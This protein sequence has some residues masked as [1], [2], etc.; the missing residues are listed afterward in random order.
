MYL[1]LEQVHWKHKTNGQRPS[2]S[3]PQERLYS[4]PLPADGA[5]TR[6]VLKIRRV[7]ERD[8]GTYECAA[9]NNEGTAVGEVELTG[10]QLT[11]DKGLSYE[12]RAP[13]LQ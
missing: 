1:D 11:N 3:N 13:H 4:P 8:Y 6:S 9:A 2:S 5:S 12:Y 10:K 7:R